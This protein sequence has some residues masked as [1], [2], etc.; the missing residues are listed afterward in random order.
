MVVQYPTIEDIHRFHSIQIEMYGGSHGV[1]DH[2]L[3]E[4]ALFAAKQT[5][6][7]VDLYPSIADK[8]A[9]LWHGFVCNHGFIDGNKRIGLMVAS[10]FLNINGCDMDLTSDE[11]EKITL[12][13]ASG[14]MTRQ[15]LIDI[16]SLK[17]I[18]Q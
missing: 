12:D 10:I 2:G 14:L 5:F 18:H 9:A 13:L 1:R 15:T 3:I 6:G 11:V 16:L 17:V 4:S 7:G 8:A